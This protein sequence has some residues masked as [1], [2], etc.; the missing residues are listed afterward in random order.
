MGTFDVSVQVRSYSAGLYPG[1]VC[2][3]GEIEG[4]GFKGGLMY[5]RVR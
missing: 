3:R 1:I 4:K 2:R 5:M